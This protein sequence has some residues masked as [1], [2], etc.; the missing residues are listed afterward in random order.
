LTFRYVY[1]LEKY[2]VA[3]SGL[4]FDRTKAFFHRD[5]LDSVDFT[6]DDFGGNVLS[7]VSYDPWGLDYIIA[8]SYD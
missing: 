3:V 2:S 7:Y 6:T 1:G 8:W 4:G 5:R